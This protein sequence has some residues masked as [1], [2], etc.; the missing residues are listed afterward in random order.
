[1]RTISSNATSERAITIF[2]THTI[3]FLSWSDEIIVQ[4]CSVVQVFQRREDDY[5]L[6]TERPAKAYIGD[7]HIEHGQLSTWPSP[8]KTWLW[9]PGCDSI[10]MLS[11]FTLSL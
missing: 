8:R 11:I 6:Y 2:K 5:R 10:S 1:M 3:D 7:M 9:A 4:A